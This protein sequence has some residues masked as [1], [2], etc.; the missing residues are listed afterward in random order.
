MPYFIF[1]TSNPCCPRR[2]S[3]RK[4]NMANQKTGVISTPNAGGMVPLTNLNN[5]S[6]GHAIMAHGN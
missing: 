1:M 3:F 6:E 4:V 2:I 5:G